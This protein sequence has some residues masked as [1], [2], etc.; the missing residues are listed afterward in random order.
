MRKAERM[1]GVVGEDQFI[2]LLR[3]FIVVH[4]IEKEAVT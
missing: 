4:F 3:D 1:S 2:C